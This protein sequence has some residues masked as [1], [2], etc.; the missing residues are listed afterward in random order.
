MQ[1][2]ILFAV[3]IGAVL[4]LTLLIRSYYPVPQA[5]V[6]LIER[7]GQFHRKLEPG[8]NFVLPIIDQPV[9][10]VDWGKVANKERRGKRV[11]MELAEQLTDTGPRPAVTKDN[12]QLDVD[13]SVYWQIIDPVRARYEVDRLPPSV[14]D[15]AL[16]VLRTAIGMVSLDQAL[17]ERTKDNQY[18]LTHLTKAC[19]K[20]GV[21]VIRVEIQSLQPSTEGVGD[22][23]VQEMRAERGRRAAI[24]NAKGESE[25]NLLKAQGEK[26]A[27]IVLAQ[28]K[29]EAIKIR[30]EAEMARIHALA[31][32]LGEA[33][34]LKAVLSWK[35]F[36]TLTEM[37]KDP[38][39]KIFLPSNGQPAIG[40]G[41]MVADLVGP[42]ERP[43]QPTE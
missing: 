15:M 30:T 43:V 20:W 8:I 19:D 5:H 35:Y 42:S 37:A 36:E 17:S 39:S 41:A 11:L 27:M 4:L 1:N 34:A 24:L 18:L 12:V 7:F 25:A 32:R 21:K 3:V 2:A 26:E 16:N 28:G 13:A 33:D 22:A 38:A 9:D 14:T 31:E 40:L 29:A 23:M 10:L 6:V